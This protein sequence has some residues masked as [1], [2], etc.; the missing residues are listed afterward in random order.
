MAMETKVFCIETDTFPAH[1]MTGKVY[2]HRLTG[3]R[4]H[5]VMYA[6]FCPE[7]GQGKVH[8]AT[9]ATELGHRAQ[10]RSSVFS[11]NIVC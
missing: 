5:N 11:S 8:T 10:R 9:L 7:Q 4:H 3:R 2:L 1:Q 6:G